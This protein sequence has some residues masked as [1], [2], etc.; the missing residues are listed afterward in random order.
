MEPGPG[1]EEQVVLPVRILISFGK[2]LVPVSAGTQASLIDIFRGFPRS[3]HVNAEIAPRSGHD[4]FPL[5]S[6]PFI[7]HPTVL[8]YIVQLLKVA[9]N[10]THMNK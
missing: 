9:Y 1:E 2:R 3:L 7:T 4:R 5:N 10:N 8:R 6:T